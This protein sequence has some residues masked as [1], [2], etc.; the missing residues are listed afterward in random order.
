MLPERQ[1]ILLLAARADCNIKTARRALA[2]GI[3]VIRGANLRERLFAALEALRPSD[4]RRRRKG[5]P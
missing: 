2:E 3:H 4:S 1:L 5:E